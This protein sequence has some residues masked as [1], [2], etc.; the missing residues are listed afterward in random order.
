MT[1]QEPTIVSIPLN[2]LTVAPENARKTHVNARLDELKASIKAYGLLQALLIRPSD[3]KGKFLVVDGQRR[4]LALKALAKEKNIKSTFPVKCEQINPDIAHE[5][6]LSANIQAQAMHPA[7]QF[8]AF[9]AMSQNN[10]SIGDIAA[11]F[12]ISEKIVKQRLKLAKIS[13]NLIALYREGEMSLEHLM[14]LTLTDDHE[15]QESLWSSLGHWQKNPRQIKAMLTEQKVKATDHRVQFIT[16]EAYERAGGHMERD[17]FSEDVY[18]TNVSL[19]EELLRQKIEDTAKIIQAEGWAF[20]EVS[21]SYDFE[22]VYDHERIHPEP[23]ELSIEDTKKLDAIEEELDALRALYNDDANNQD[24]LDEKWDSL[25][26]EQ[27]VIEAKKQAYT[28]EQISNAGVYV[29]YHNGELSVIRGLVK[30]ADLTNEVKKEPKK[31]KEISE[32]LLEQLTTHQTIALQDRLS[33]SPEIAFDLLLTEMVKATF[34]DHMKYENSCFHI[35]FGTPNIP[36][37]DEKLTTCFGAANRQ[38]AFQSWENMLKADHENLY[39][40]VSALKAEQKMQ[41]LA[42]CFAGTLDTIKHPKAYATKDQQ[43]K[44]QELITLLDLDMREYWKPTASLYFNHISKDN[45]LK[46]IKEVKGKDFNEALK[47]LKKSELALAAEKQL[48]NS[49]W[50]PKPLQTK[51]DEPDPPL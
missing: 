5:L 35:N 9:L 28:A 3:K 6:S 45:I 13:P 4:L 50:L 27:E 30:K 11:R 31:K 17:L 12:G 2:H 39:N 42:F 46:I 32:R 15:K 41:L 21:T 48:E 51:T 7:D 18:L 20:V 36:R 1:N 25:Q 44:I 26:A 47:K 16:L 37:D 8:E 33:L 14:A 10:I 34:P 43:N 29:S 23:V 38:K 19:V 40:N 22:F 24:D 49:N